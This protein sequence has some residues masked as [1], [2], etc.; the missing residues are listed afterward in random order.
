MTVEFLLGNR[1][2]RD[3]LEDQDVEG[4]IMLNGSSSIRPADEGSYEFE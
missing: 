1:K 2:A 4:S 3:H